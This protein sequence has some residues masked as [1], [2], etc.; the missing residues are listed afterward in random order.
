MKLICRHGK[1][2]AFVEPFNLH[3]VEISEACPPS[4]QIVTTASSEHFQHPPPLQ[5][6]NSRFE[7]FAPPSN[8]HFVD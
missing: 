3:S 1:F 8:R 6:Q 7:A 4:C 2:V 5:A